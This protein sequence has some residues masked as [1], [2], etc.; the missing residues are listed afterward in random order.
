MSARIK[1]SKSIFDKALN[2][3]ATNYLGLSIQLS[4]DGFS[5]CIL[6]PKEA[7]Y[8]ALQ[9][10]KF[11]DSS[12]QMALSQLL[13]ELIPSVDWLNLPYEG[14]KI[15]METHKSTLVPHAFYDSEYSKEQFA[16]NAT[17][18]KDDILLNDY[19][20]LLDAINVWLING[21]LYD[22]IIK[23]FPLA[24]IHNHGSVLIESALA[25][26][27]S[28]REETPLFTHVRKNWFDVVV[29]NNGELVFYNSFRYKAKE[30]FIYFLIYVLE[31]LELNPDVIQLY[32]LGEVLKISEIYDITMMY[33][34]NVSFALPFD[35]VSFG[36]NLGDIPLH[37]YFNLLNH[38]QCEL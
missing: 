15:L 2:K 29:I 35:N 37:F 6:N 21:K 5:F 34:R 4:T 8:L 24:V 14:V 7:K 26:A 1:L 31:Q 10:Y 27:N 19:L 12:N 28:H 33:I 38:Y 20:P 36:F 11:K 16:F 25:L 18:N 22:T 17:I 23:Y 9:S 13:D 30:D 32:L 3:E